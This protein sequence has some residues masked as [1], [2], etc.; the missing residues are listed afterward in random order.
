[1]P[2]TFS[3]GEA[4]QL[5]RY[6]KFTVLHFS[7][8]IPAS[9]AVVISPP[10][11]FF[12]SRPAV[13]AVYEIRYSYVVFTERYNFG[14]T[15][16]PDKVYYELHQFGWPFPKGMSVPE[17]REGYYCGNRINLSNLENHC[18]HIFSGRDIHIKLWNATGNAPEDVYFD[19]SVWYY[20]FHKKYVE[21]VYDILFKQWDLTQRII[22]LLAENKLL[23]NEFLDWEYKKAGAELGVI[24]KDIIEDI[25]KKKTR[26]D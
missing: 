5:V 8:D 9:E 21:K 18:T 14:D 10:Y 2:L 20:A 12:K 6:G 16:R 22:D 7:L 13:E 25:L 15:S 1:M 3:F 24:P 4:A 11:P 26:R 23:M 17:Y 19:I